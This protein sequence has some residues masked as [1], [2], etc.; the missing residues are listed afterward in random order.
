[1]TSL[2]T[3]FPERILPRAIPLLSLLLLLLT[4]NNKSVLFARAAV[5]SETWPLG[6]YK[7][8]T[9]AFKN[10]NTDDSGTTNN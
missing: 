1:M 7:N 8:Q 4:E 3:S 5:L 2:S 10:F 9:I 6:I